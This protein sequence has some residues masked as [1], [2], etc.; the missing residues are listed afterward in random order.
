MD[1]LLYSK[2]SSYA[3]NKTNKCTPKWIY[4]FDKLSQIPSNEFAKYLKKF[5]FENASNMAN[6]FKVAVFGFVYLCGLA[7]L[8]FDGEW[9]WDQESMWKQSQKNVLNGQCLFITGSLCFC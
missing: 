9:F 7:L 2:A 1:N 5:D 4:T 6:T 8:I 3:R